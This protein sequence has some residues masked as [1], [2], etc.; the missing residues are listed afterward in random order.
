MRLH[1][2]EDFEQLLLAAAEHFGSAGLSPSAI[3]KD[4]Y[5][6]EAIGLPKSV[7]VL[8]A[9]SR[10]DSALGRAGEGKGTFGAHDIDECSHA[11]DS[12]ATNP[13]PK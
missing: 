4:Y 10:L 6:T 5:V 2:H 11:T 12:A 1:E 9:E 3:E 7:P 13:S 8:R